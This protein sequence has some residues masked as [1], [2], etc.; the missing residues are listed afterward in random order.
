MANVDYKDWVLYGGE[1]YQLLACVD[2]DNLKK[3]D[4]NYTIIGKVQAK[5]EE[6]F[7]QI[8][9]ADSTEKISNL[10]KTYNHFGDTNEI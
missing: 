10:D 8:N 3:L 5:T 9:Y 2:S 4:T 7:V 6:N 1:D